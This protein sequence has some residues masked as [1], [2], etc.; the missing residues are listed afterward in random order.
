MYLIK[1]KVKQNKK[2]NSSE[3][4]SFSVILKNCRNTGKIQLR[5]KEREMSH[6]RFGFPYS[7]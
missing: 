2:K 4:C 1:S 3:I 7:S 5:N 6:K